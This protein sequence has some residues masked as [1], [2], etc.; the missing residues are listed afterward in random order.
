MCFFLYR[1]VKNMKRGLIITVAG[2]LVALVLGLAVAYPLFVSSFPSLSKLNL[3]VDV[4]YA[5]VQPIG[6]NSNLTGLWWNESVVEVNY[7]GGVPGG[8]IKADGLVVS[9]LIVLNV[10]NNSNEAARIRNF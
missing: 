8:T 7:N 6:S 3:S 4:S 9:Y 10:T 1:A 2:C 5:F